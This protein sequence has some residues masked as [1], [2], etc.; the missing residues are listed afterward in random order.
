M[1]NKL[2]VSNQIAYN[3]FITYDDS[4]LKRALTIR[5]QIP[6]TDAVQDERNVILLI[7]KER[8]LI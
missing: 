6:N 3:L 4:S 8:N 7:M 1:K 2:S 5:T